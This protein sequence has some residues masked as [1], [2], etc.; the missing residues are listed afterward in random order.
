MKGKKT[1]AIELQKQ[2]VKLAEGAEKTEL[3]RVLDSYKEGK[4]PQAN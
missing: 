1:K 4:L 2:A 3:Q